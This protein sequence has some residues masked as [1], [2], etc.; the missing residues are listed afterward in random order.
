MYFKKID[1]RLIFSL[2]LLFS[3]FPGMAQ[4]PVLHAHNDYEHERPLFDALSYG[5]HSVEADIHLWEGRLVVAHDEPVAPFLDF[6]EAYLFP[7]RKRWQENE[8]KVYADDERPFFLLIDVKTEAKATWETLQKLLS[9]Y[10][11]ILELGNKAGGVRPIISGNRSPELL[12]DTYTLAAYD[13]RPSDLGKGHDALRM[14][15][16]S[17]NYVKVIGSLNRGIPTEEE[18]AKISSLAKKVHA[19]GKLFRLWFTPESEEVWEILLQCGVDILNTDD[20][21]RART[22]VNSKDY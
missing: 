16:I 9:N 8:G 22:F 14:P 19:E 4:G 7:L 17:E 5:F 1:W 10:D 13:G 3:V 12:S 2:C 20:L 21:A 15:W 6:E 18:Q 11:D